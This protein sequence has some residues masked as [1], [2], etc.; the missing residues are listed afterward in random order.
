M[1]MQNGTAVLEDFV[2]FLEK[3]NILWPYD[4]AVSLLGICPKEL[5]TYVHTKIC[6]QVFVVHCPVT[7]LCPTLWPHDLQHTRLSCPSPTSGTCSNSC[8]LS[9][10]C[11]PIVSSSVAHPPTPLP[12]PALH[13]SQHQGLFHTGVYSSS[14]H[15]CQISEAIRLFF[16]RWMDKQ[17]YI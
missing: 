3:L 12:P 17:W 5:K 2:W 9:W 7:K 16:S 13:L 14:I 6:T 11:H 10:W 4:P 8:P 15:N 1:G